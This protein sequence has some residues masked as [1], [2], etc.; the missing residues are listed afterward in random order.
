MKSQGTISFPPLWTNC[1][2]SEETKKIINMSPAQTFCRQVLYSSPP[3]AVPSYQ[4]SGSSGKVDPPVRWSLYGRIHF[5]S[6]DP[7]PSIWRCLIRLSKSKDTGSVAVL[8]LKALKSN[9]GWACPYRYNDWFLVIP[10]LFQ[11]DKCCTAF[12][13]FWDSLHHPSVCLSV[14]ILK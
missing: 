1:D 2:F 5:A 7:Q 13:P 8:T 14:L 9:T 4:Q 6:Y 10:G 12:V 11:G 3:Q